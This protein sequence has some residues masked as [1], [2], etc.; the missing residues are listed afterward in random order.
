MIGLIA[1]FVPMLLGAPIGGFLALRARTHDRRF[2]SVLLEYVV[3]V[4]V[5]AIL[6]S[7][8]A[9]DFLDPRDGQASLRQHLDYAGMQFLLMSLLAFPATLLGWKVGKGKADAPTD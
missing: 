5:I 6:L 4:G 9:A 7:W 3:T 8:M 2:K 1:L